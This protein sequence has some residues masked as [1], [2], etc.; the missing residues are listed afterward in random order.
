MVAAFHAEQRPGG[1]VRG[2]HR[3]GKPATCVAEPDGPEREGASVSQIAQPPWLLVNADDK[4]ASAP[5]SLFIPPR[6]QR[7]NLT[8][9]RIARLL[10]GFSPREVGGVLCDG[11]RICVEVIA[12]QPNGSYVGRR[13]NDPHVLTELAHGALIEFNAAHVIAIQRAGGPWATGA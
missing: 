11:E 9:G 1:A 7:E 13:A 6:E 8:V 12:V 4:H 10:L 5:R 2:G 3:S